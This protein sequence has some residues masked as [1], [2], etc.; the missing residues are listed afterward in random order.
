MTDLKNVRGIIWDLDGT[1]Y[2]FNEAFRLACN[3][4][5]AKAARTVDDTLVYEDALALAMK[6]ETEQGFSLYWFVTHMGMKYEDL[7]F[8]FHKSLDEKIIEQNEKM[9]AALRTL[10]IPSVILTN[11]SRD[12]VKRIL[13]HLGMDDIFG[14]SI[15]LALEDADF[16]PKSK[17]STGFDKALK[18]LKLPAD[19]VILVDDLAKNLIKAKELGLM[20]AL[21]HH[22]ALEE[23]VAAYADF[24]SPDTVEFIGRLQQTRTLDI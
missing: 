1:L 19:Q 15:I 20:T 14:D 22:G 8:P 5:A 12:W 3:H 23:N 21:I 4:A 9:G 11:A 7:H 2:R 24:T 16:Q 6:G 18:I 10:D 17:G 13:V